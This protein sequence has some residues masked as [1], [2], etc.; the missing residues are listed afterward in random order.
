MRMIFLQ[1][2]VFGMHGGTGRIISVMPLPSKIE[3]AG[4][5][6]HNTEVEALLR[7]ERRNAWSDAIRMFRF[8]TWGDLEKKVEALRGEK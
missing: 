7:E 5:Y 3:D 1:R 6:I 8:G 2:L 4:M